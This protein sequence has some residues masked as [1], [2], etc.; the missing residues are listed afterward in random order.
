MKELEV[1]TS[2]ATKDCLETAAV[3]VLEGGGGG[4]NME[5]K[6]TWVMRFISIERAPIDGTYCRR[7]LAD[8]VK[9]ENASEIDQ[10]I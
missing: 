6:E 4:K 7:Q 10:S 2:Y 3:W 1:I 9:R 5:K 8:Q